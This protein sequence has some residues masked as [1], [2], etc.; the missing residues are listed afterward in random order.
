MEVDEHEA[1]IIEAIKAIRRK[2]KRPDKLSISSYFKKHGL[3]LESKQVSDLIDRML[4]SA[5]IYNKPTVSGLDSYYVFTIGLDQ[6]S[7]D[8][9]EKS[10]SLSRNEAGL[11]EFDQ[12]CSL[13]ESQNE[14]DL[15]LRDSSNLNLAS[16]VNA[17][18]TLATFAAFGNMAN[19]I[20][21]LN[22]LLKNER[23]ISSAL[24]LENLQLM[25][26]VQELRTKVDSQM[27]SLKAKKP[28]KCEHEVIVIPSQDE[29]ASNKDVSRG[30]CLD[31]TQQ[32]KEIQSEKHR[33]YLILKSTDQ[34]K[35]GLNNPNIVLETIEI[36]KET[37]AKHKKRPNKRQRKNNNKSKSQATISKDNLRSND[38]NN[39]TQNQNDKQLPEEINNRKQ[40]E[41]RIESK[42]I[43]ESKKT[44]YFVGD[45]ML[46]DVKGWE[47]NDRCGSH[48]SVYVK[49]FSGSTVCDM[50]SYI[51]PTI[52]RKPDCIVL[53]VGTND[54]AKK[55]KTD[56]EISKNI[57]DLA[58][59][60]EEN[61]IKPI[62]SGLIPRYDALEPKRVKVNL[63]LRDLC[64]ENKILYTDHANIDPSKNLNRSK[65]HLNKLGV[66][67]F[68][69]NLFE[70][71]KGN[72]Q[73]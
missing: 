29:I 52:D 4:D 3:G 48:E 18:E 45:S 24:R 47:L 65:L 69:N 34:K 27:N 51:K 62:I 41:N 64:K 43:T 22:N 6:A 19:A 63:A 66:D 2:S 16:N 32:L 8:G 68:T 56:V 13:E 1:N 40:P 33:E 35:S 71:A 73:H 14:L 72:L 17:N 15:G 10:F 44:T 25:S 28:N 26:K 5:A 58:K 70:I 59:N 7:D 23:E 55:S 9:N 30:T 39:T 36:D 37:T 11:F 20:L 53:H 46:K 67:I 57:V 21:E 38:N 60:I 31:L 49:S 12:T 42:K 54:L 50:E 61:G